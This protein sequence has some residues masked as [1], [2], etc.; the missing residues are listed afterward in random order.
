MQNF[1]W[2]LGNA[3]LITH[4]CLVLFVI[5]GLI[6]AWLGYFQRW[7][8]VRNF[9]FRAIHLM[10]LG[11]IIAQTALGKDCPLTIWENQL[12]IKAG[13]EA[14]YQHGCITYWIDRFLFYD[15]DQKM[16]NTIYYVFFALVVLSW[17]VVRPRWPFK[18]GRSS[19]PK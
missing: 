2:Y 16:L 9:Y 14:V 19:P 18:A 3:I 1:Y 10:L 13:G 8:F 4:F 7:Q 17:L 12:R 5:G 15:A 11:F 6:V